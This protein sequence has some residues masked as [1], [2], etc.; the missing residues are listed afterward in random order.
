M[1]TGLPFEVRAKLSNHWSCV[2]GV[3]YACPESSSV[4]LGS[5]ASQLIRTTGSFSGIQNFFCVVLRLKSGSPCTVEIASGQ[6]IESYSPKPQK[7]QRAP[8]PPALHP[9][10]LLSSQAAS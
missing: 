2:V 10:R 3:S 6:G 9:S 1:K 8:T 5:S 4:A 7:R